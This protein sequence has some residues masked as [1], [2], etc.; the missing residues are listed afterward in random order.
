MLFGVVPLAARSRGEATRAR[1][2]TASSAVEIAAEEPRPER[3]RR[4]TQSS[5]RL[6]LVASVSSFVPF[7]L[8]VLFVV[9]IRPLRLAID[10]DGSR[11]SG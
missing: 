3:W 11:S 2:R 6:P 9:R 4:P 7:V 5:R 8:F 10:R 1:A